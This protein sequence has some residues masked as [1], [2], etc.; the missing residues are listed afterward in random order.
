VEGVP[1][2]GLRKAIAL[3]IVAVAAAVAGHELRVATGHKTAY[4]LGIYGSALVLAVF[5]AAAT[6]ATAR[7]VDRVATARAGK[8]A[9]T[10]LRI[11]ILL[12]GYVVTGLS[13]L[14]LLRF[15]LNRL[16]LGGAVTGVV[17]G[18]AAQPVLGNFF[19]GMVLLFA[20]PYQPGDYVRVRSGSLGGPH[21]GTV[22]TVSLQYTTLLTA[23]GPLRIP[24]GGMLAAAVGPVPRP[25]TVPPTT[26]PPTTVPPP[27]VPPPAVPPSP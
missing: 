19:A 1:T 17:V 12:V 22:E 16:L 10:P 27:T 26:V 15:D 14:A 4:H 11:T 21:D 2:L 18:I 7:E 9:A 13:V 20:R 3:G 23:D 24:N 25:P 8:A 5:G 6:R